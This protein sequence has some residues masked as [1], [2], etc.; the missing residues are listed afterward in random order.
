VE[1]SCLAEP[2]LRPVGRCERRLYRKFADNGGHV[3]VFHGQP[4]TTVQYLRQW[5]PGGEF[6]PETPCDLDGLRKVVADWYVWA[7]GSR[8]TAA[9]SASHVAEAPV[10]DADEWPDVTT[11]WPP[12]YN[13]K[14]VV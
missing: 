2:A 6:V 10:A 4:P 5:L 3:L 14:T 9:G 13:G 8:S 7:N 11:R 1:G 12:D